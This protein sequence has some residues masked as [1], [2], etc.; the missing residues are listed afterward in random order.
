M[1]DAWFDSTARVRPWAGRWILAATL[2]IGVW[3]FGSTASAAEGTS[4][5]T[6]EDLADKTLMVQTSGGRL[7][8][9]E[10]SAGMCKVKVSG[11]GSIWTIEAMDDGS[12]CGSLWRNERLAPRTLQFPAVG[13]GKMPVHFEL[14]PAR[15]KEPG[16]LT[17]TL[18]EDRRVQGLDQGRAAYAY[19]EDLGWYALTLGA[20]AKAE[21][22]GATLGSLDDD[23]SVWVAYAEVDDRG[24]PVAHHVVPLTVVAPTPTPPPGS[25]GG[26]AGS[27]GGDRAAGS[28]APPACNPSN[29]PDTAYVCAWVEGTTIRFEQAPPPVIRPNVSVEVE[30]IHPSDVNVDVRLTG[31][32][33]LFVPGDRFTGI[34]GNAQSKSPRP[35]PTQQRVR[36]RF[37]PRA[38]GDADVEITITDDEGRIVA[39]RSL[40]FVVDRTYAGAVRLG[41]GIVYADAVDR[42]Y[43]ART[44]GTNEQAQIVA[45]RGG[46]SGFELVLG[47]APYVF[48]YIQNRGHGRSYTNTRLRDRAGGFAPFAGLGLVEAS[49]TGVEV[50]KSLH[51]GLE[52]EPTPN[53]SIAA[54]AVSRRVTR[55]TEGAQ[56]GDPVTGEVPTREVIRWGGGVVLNFS[57]DFFRI[58]T[59]ESRS[60]YRTRRR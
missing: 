8:A 43:E 51:M 25:T 11:S 22:R 48:D 30:V 40:E 32:R 60:P 19:A 39:S 6:L 37:A 50:L 23:E 28:V 4:T 58:A 29:D 1:V 36:H 3:G 55:L 9:G 16:P 26:D 31:K 34:D 12:E 38:P 5:Y 54:T 24:T 17:L 56:V 47:Y 49:D 53:F 52:W 14:A 41:F 13:G 33:G 59:R 7:K 18:D 44:I 42:H 45:T 46:N 10:Q 27:S 57:T 15:A 20:D 2:G 35:P 21:L